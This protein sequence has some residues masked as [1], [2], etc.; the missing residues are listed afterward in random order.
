MNWLYYKTGRSIMAA[1]VF[2]VSANLF[3]EIFATDPD[4]KAIQTG[5]LL[6][7]SVIVLLKDRKLFFTS[8]LSV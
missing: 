5:L 6:V 4:S 1:I 3:N 8:T 2:H 7:L